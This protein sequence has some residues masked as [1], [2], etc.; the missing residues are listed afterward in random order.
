MNKEEY[1]Y[2]VYISWHVIQIYAHY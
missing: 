2:T 1:I